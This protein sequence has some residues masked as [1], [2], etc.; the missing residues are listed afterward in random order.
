MSGCIN[1][2]Q[3]R[4][5][6]SGK[7]SLHRLGTAGAGLCGMTFETALTGV[8]GTHEHKRAGESKLS[9]CSRNGNRAVLKGLTEYLRYLL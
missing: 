2:V 8:H 7:I 1:S 6:Y 5:A 4:P 3:E 9:V